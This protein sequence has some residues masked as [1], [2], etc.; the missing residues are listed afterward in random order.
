[1]E[2]DLIIIGWGAAGFSAA[3]KA[4]E[5]SD[6]EMK[7]ALIGLGK[8]GGTCVNVGCVPSKFLIEKSLRINETLYK[9]AGKT[10]KELFSEVMNELR[11]TVSSSRTGKYEKVIKNYENVDLFYGEA[12]F[13]DNT[14]VMVK[15]EEGTKAI[16]GTYILI[17][18]GSSPSIPSFA[19]RENVRTS[20]NFWDINELPSKFAIVGGGPIGLEIGQA[21]RRF[22]SDVAIFEIADEIL[23]GYSKEIQSTAR[24]IMENDGIMLHTGARIEKIT[25]ED[26]KCIHYGGIKECFDEILVAAGRH[27]NTSSLNLEAAGVKTDERGYILT[28]KFMKTSSENIFSAGDCVSGKLKLETL[29]AREGVI[30]VENIFGYSSE[31]DLN[32]TPWAIFTI[33]NIAGVG[34]NEREASQ[35][36]LNFEKRVID[37]SN[38][39][40]NSIS[41]NKFGFAKLITERES[42]KIIGIEVISPEAADFIVEGVYA[43]KYGLTVEDVINATH[44]FPSHSEIIKIAAQSFKRDL[45]KMSCCME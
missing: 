28:D 31:I 18:T 33:P 16:K 23:P 40:R 39:V 1:M 3:I 22:G 36:G 21:M 9:Q 30:A 13:A 26:G 34:I 44:I 14:S 45:S 17:S 29:S 35:K 19:N 11:D 38:A 2:Y 7:I 12:S 20:D 4:S 37:A 5:I 32:S 25:Q 24:N 6:G 42:R 27:P 15:N 10:R 41:G 43:V 8:M